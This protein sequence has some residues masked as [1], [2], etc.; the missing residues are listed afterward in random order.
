MN[1]QISEI[2][3]GLALSPVGAQDDQSALKTPYETPL[4][5]THGRMRQVTLQ[6]GSTPPIVIGDGGV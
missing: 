5:T 3:N 6:T 4:L 2:K 1:P